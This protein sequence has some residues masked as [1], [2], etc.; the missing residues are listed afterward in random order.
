MF[1]VIATW[2][3]R[4]YLYALDELKTLVSQVPLE[5]LQQASS[6]SPSAF[7]K[8]FPVTYRWASLELVYHRDTLARSFLAWW[9]LPLQRSGTTCGTDPC[10]I[11]HQHHF[12]NLMLC[13]QTRWGGCGSCIVQLKMIWKIGEIVLFY[14]NTI[15]IST[16]LFCFSLLLLLL[17]LYCC[18]HLETISTIYNGKYSE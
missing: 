3:P 13:G 7:Y 14:F 17:L 8:I 6:P 18:F 2:A 9:H 15:L 1:G 5:P 11:W 10:H 4:D 16:C 12:H